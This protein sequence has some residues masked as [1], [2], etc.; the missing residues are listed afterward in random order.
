MNPLIP[1]LAISGNPTNRQISKMLTGFHEAGIDSV[2]IYPRTGLG[3]PYM[4]EEWRALCGQIIDLAKQL[5][6]HIW[7]YDELNWPSG[8]CGNQVIAEDASFAPQRFVCENGVVR[9]ERIKPRGKIQSDAFDNDML[10]PEA[11]RCFIRLTHERYKAWFGADFGSVITGIFTDEPSFYYNVNQPGMYPYYDGVTADYAAACGGDLVAD[12]A[13][14]E[15]G[16]DTP[17]FPGVLRRLIGERF[18]T[19]YIDQI[20][21]WC[22]ENGL[23]LTG[24]TLGDN[25]PLGSTRNTGEWFSFIDQLD[26]PGVDE[27]STRVES[28]NSTDDILFSMA[29]NLRENGKEHV[30][31][32]LFAL[33]PCSMSYARRRQML[34]YAAAHG[35]DRYFIAISHMDAAGNVGKPDYFN[36]F[37]YASPDF[38]MAKLLAEEANRAAA[39]AGKRTVCA[40]GLRC[41]FRAYLRGLGTRRGTAIEDTFNDLTY[42]FTKRQIGWRILREDESCDCPL[43]L[44][45]T[46]NGV[47]EERSGRLYSAEQIVKLA[48][49][50]DTGPRVTDAEG[51]LMPDLRVK[52]YRDGSVVVIDRADRP[53]GRRACFLHFGGRVIPFTQEN[54][55]VFLYTPDEETDD[56]I[57]SVKSAP[58]QRVPLT[59]ER[60]TSPG[61]AVFRACFLQTDTVSFDV[62]APLTVNIHGREY[63]QPHDVFLD[64]K[65]LAFSQP[66]DVLTDCFAPFYRNAT[67]FLAPGTHTLKTALPD[68]PYLPAV[69]I[70]GAFRQQ[71]NTLLP[72][73]DTGMIGFFG[74]LELSVPVDVP[75]NAA[76][77]A[78]CISDCGLYVTARIQGVP[79]AEQAVA[80][81]RF[82]IP[83]HL[84]GRNFEVTLTLHSTFAPL[85]GELCEWMRQGVFCPAPTWRGVPASSPE[86]LDADGFSVWEE[87]Q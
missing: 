68:Y 10:N 43:V 81:Y 47:L 30:M 45:V 40:V 59:V 50:K 11:V 85:F 28:F 72:W 15:A 6:M 60:I 44:S 33:G 75:K 18:K 20:A 66:S 52:A 49:E 53:L 84:F 57:S 54:D 79:F 65:K 21:A 56:R 12:M 67:C 87:W 42:A 73:S 80:P 82:S 69:L 27:I 37:T 3:V 63:P 14:F 17:N 31:A 36:N 35:I 19:A 62:T 55:G 2:M 83:P 25:T 24:H 4:S 16:K 39:L 78:V 34:W 22:R 77:A 46:E 8:S 51:K 74:R 86:K 76:A 1:M 23:L 41:P 13:A 5:S 26:L 58:E 70:T 38:G 71:Q 48:E 61:P 9:V 7:L 29:E 64:G 32:E